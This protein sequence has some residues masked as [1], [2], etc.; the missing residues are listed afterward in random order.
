[1]TTTPRVSRA[2]DA[3]TPRSTTP[4]ADAHSRPPSARYL[5]WRRR[6]SSSADPGVNTSAGVAS[7]SASGLARV[8]ASWKAP[9]M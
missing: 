2:S 8:R 9:V 6:W 7:D 3:A 4:R 1:M 5:P